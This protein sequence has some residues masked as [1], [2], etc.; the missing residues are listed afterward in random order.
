MSD[1]I[2]VVHA[3]KRQNVPILRFNDEC[4]V[5]RNLARWV[6]KSAQTRLGETVMIVRPIGEDLK[7]RKSFGR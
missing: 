1:E 5:C 3:D 2:A 7:I 6:R 4:G